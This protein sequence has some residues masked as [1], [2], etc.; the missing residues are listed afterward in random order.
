MRIEIGPVTRLEG[1]LN[2]LTEVEDNT[3]TEARCVGE[4]FRGFE[5]ILRGRDPLDAQQITQ[6]ICGVC[7]YAHAIASSYAQE[8]AYGLQPPPNGRIIHNLIQGANQ[9]HDYLLSFYQLSALDFV[10]ITAVLQY[11]GKDQDLKV[12]WVSCWRSRKV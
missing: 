9:L 6:R 11:Q 10:D 1:H 4:M 3:I 12:S 2:V 7:P 8:Q 5:M